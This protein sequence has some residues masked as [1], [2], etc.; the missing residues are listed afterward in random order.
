LALLENGERGREREGM[1]KGTWR[2]AKRKKKRKERD[3][4]EG[5]TERKRDGKKEER[6][7]RKGKREQKERRKI[8]EGLLLEHQSK[9]L[10]QLH[11][12]FPPTESTTIH[13][14]VN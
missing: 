8:N 14:L 9:T 2:K 5:K 13:L 10:L 11:D 1:T 7:M 4:G 6:N 3:G 12:I